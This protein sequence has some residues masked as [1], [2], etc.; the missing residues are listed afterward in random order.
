MS[1][2]AL[3]F[4]PD[5][6]TARTVTQVLSE[7]EFQVETC[8]EP[9][10]S[11]KKL[12]AEHFDAIVVD[13]ENEQNA[14][15]LF[16]SARNSG[17]N[18]A[19]LSIA[20]VE[21]QAGVA[22]AFRIGANLVLTKPIN[23]EQ[24][25]GTIRVARGLLRK[26]E[27]AKAGGQS[28]PI[29]APQM[30][31]AR[32][33]A[34]EMK[35][36]PSTLFE[37]EAEPEARPA[38]TEAAFLESIP[39]P[40]ADLARSASAS[41]KAPWQPIS[42]PMA[43]ALQSAAEATSQSKSPFAAENS[44]QPVFRSSESSGFGAA[45]APARE[46]APVAPDF[47]SFAGTQESG[48]S[49][50]FIIAAVVLVTAAALGYVVLSKNHAFLGNLFHRATPQA[51]ALHPQSM[52]APSAAPVTAASPDTT[53]A[54]GNLST[55]VSP[56]VPANVISETSAPAAHHETAPAKPKKAAS[57]ITQEAPPA[58]STNEADEVE[59]E[60]SAIVVRGGS[61]RKIQQESA[62]QSAPDAS[63]PEVLSVASNSNG[64]AI[65]KLV[66][67]PTS[68]PHAAPQTLKVS[69]GVSQGLLVKKVAPIYPMQAMQMRI[70]GAVQMAATI[71]K[72]GNITNVKVLSGDSILA[73]SA[74][75]AVKQWKYKPYYLDGQ[76][77]EI[78][79]QITVN[80][81]LP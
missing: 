73:R 37:V 56:E 58:K 47:A 66:D 7:L 65:S 44:A 20:V 77:V 62:P 11:V 1:Y 27:A 40:T 5:E 25:K 34:P 72:E 50:K 19:S 13:C 55:P 29:D 49:K 28:A 60:P 46:K 24:S 8:N 42:K 36:P 6:K 74:A 70:E 45:V 15:L 79:T 14:T 43:T 4:C 80:F 61:Q 53:A 23:V 9:F 68:V 75:A 57:T 12:T 30:P 54:P 3:L 26:S 67:A 59:E 33:S 2:K 39:D 16:K 63:A 38:A 81:K 51:Q 21:G 69:Q 35:T 10:A 48:G 78:Q 17:S 22:K 71:S 32:P 64:E 18:Q 31:P 52:A 41:A 76:A